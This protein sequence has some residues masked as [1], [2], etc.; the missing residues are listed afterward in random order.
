MPKSL[1][2]VLSWFF[3]S[4][5][6]GAGLLFILRPMAGLFLLIAV[7]TFLSMTVAPIAH[8]VMRRRGLTVEETLSSLAIGVL[9]LIGVLAFSGLFSF[10]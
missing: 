8:I 2:I 5:F 6:V 7:T 1:K 10:T 3:G 4:A 9:V